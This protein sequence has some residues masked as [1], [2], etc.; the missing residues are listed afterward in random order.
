MKYL[1]ILIVFFTNLSSTIDLTRQTPIEKTVFLKGKIGLNHFYEP[2]E[3]IFYTGKLYKL[4]IKNVS[5]SKHYFGSDLFSKSIFTRKIQVTKNAN[6]VAEIK[7]II[8]EVEVW[9]NE[10][11]EWWFVPLK[12]GVFLDLI[13]NVKD[14]KTQLNHSEMGMKGKIIIK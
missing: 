11:L 6:K 4:I 8:N 12:T 5:D 7:G 1:V 10:G 13:C 14:K 2:S 9:P 3:L